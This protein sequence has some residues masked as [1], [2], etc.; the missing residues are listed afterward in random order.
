MNGGGITLADGGLADT[1]RHSGWRHNRK[2]VHNSLRR[3]QQSAS[4]LNAFSTCGWRSF[5]YRTV[6]PPHAYRLAGSSCHDRFCTPCAN[7][8]SRCI[9]SN[10][11]KK[12]AREPARFATLTIRHTTEPLDIQVRR[13]YA[14][15]TKLRA[16]TVWKRHVTGGCAFIEIKWIATTRE[17]HPHLHCVLHGRYFPKQLLSATWH[18]IT[19]DS[20]ITDIRAITD[21]AKIAHYVTKYAAKS[22]NDTFLNRPDLLDEVVTC[23]RGRRLCHTFGTW[24]GLKLTEIPNDRDWESIGSFHD[25]CLRAIDGDPE[26][27]DAITMICRDRRAE[28]LAAVRFARPPPVIKTETDVQLSFTWPAIDNRY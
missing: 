28:I 2:L 13:L 18:A 16:G 5:V 6:D 8:R 21:E 14:S 11:L 10:V 26:A 22:V 1:F 7:D 4:R 15:F 9:A 20:F 17:W 12:L 19:G 23:L 3:T 27:E 25:V 24:R